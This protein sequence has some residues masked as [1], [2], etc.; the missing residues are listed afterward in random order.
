MDQR[1]RTLQ[2]DAE[3]SRD[4]THAKGTALAQRSKPRGGGLTRLRLRRNGPIVDADVVPR[5]SVNG[6]LEFELSFHPIRAE[7]QQSWRGRRWDRRPEGHV[8]S[9]RIVEEA[10]FRSHPQTA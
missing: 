8:W 1:K 2:G 4:L 5:A 9:D 10:S 7:P 3:V 6:C